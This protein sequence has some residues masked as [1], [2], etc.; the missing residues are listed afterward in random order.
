MKH[1]TNLR[2]PLPYLTIIIITIINTAQSEYLRIC[3]IVRTEASSVGSLP[4]GLL[5]G[6]MLSVDVNS[7]TVQTQQF[8]NTLSHSQTK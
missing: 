7:F 2:L 3:R 1:Y 4:P 8:N 5:I 6:G